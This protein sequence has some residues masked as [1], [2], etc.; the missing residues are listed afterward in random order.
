MC[1]IIMV[2]MNLILLCQKIVHLI[3]LVLCYEPGKSIGREADS[4]ERN[5]AGGIK[6]ITL[7]VHKMSCT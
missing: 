2:G 1:H 4:N 6:L 7:L 3:L 5:I